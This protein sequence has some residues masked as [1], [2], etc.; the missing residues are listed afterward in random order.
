MENK[1]KP[2]HCGNHTDE[3]SRLLAAAPMMLA[4]LEQVTTA[5]AQGWSGE[6]LKVALD[7]ARAAIAAAKGAA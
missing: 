4:A 3:E 1:G 7:N 5:A 6:L 2:R